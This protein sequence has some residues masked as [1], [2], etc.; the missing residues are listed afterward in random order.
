MRAV[1][2]SSRSFGSRRGREGFTL[3]EALLA[4]AI[5]IVLIG[6]VAVS[7]TRGLQTKHSQSVFIELQQNLR[8]A[9]Q[10][11]TQDLRSTS[12]LGLWNDPGSGCDDPGDACSARDRLAILISKGFYTSVAESPG[13]S[14]NN[15]VE[16]AVCDAS[17]F[18]DGDLVLITDGSN[19]DLVTI[20]QIQNLRDFSQPCRPAGSAAGGN[21]PNHDKIQHNHDRIS[22]TWNPNTYAFK[23]QLVTYELRPDPSDATRTVLY[24]RT[25]LGSSEGPFSG[26][27]AFDVDTLRLSYGIPLNPTAG[28]TTVQQLRF[29]DSLSAAAAA[30]GS[31][32]TDDPRGSGI[33][34]GSLV[35]AVRVYL[36][37][38]TPKDLV[39]GGSPG[40]FEITETVDLR[41][42]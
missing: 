30:L 37:G 10:Q 2:R 36:A 29:Y 7:L 40:R 35:R 33:Y 16:T 31:A 38:T 27:V 3:I 22:G 1:S 24:R 11:I 17:G 8:N 23:V 41:L 13:N 9:M 20:T 6:I 19:A 42:N 26:I 39:K 15:S 34:V 14:Y 5:L 32:Y 4:I 25:G 18:S 28:S 21:P 12:Q